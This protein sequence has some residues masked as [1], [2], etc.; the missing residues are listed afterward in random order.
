MEVGTGAR[1]AF[2]LHAPIEVPSEEFFSALRS[3][4]EDLVKLG[5][6]FGAD[7]RI[8][9]Q[10]PDDTAGASDSIDSERPI[11][12]EPIQGAVE[13]SVTDEQL[14]VLPAHAREIGDLL[15][16]IADT[17][18]SIV[19]VGPMHHIVEPKA[20]D[21]F[22]SLTFKR[23]KGTT[24][25]QLHEWWLNQHPTVVCLLMLPDMLAYDQVHVDH[26]L[27]EQTALD[28]GFTYRCYDSYDNLTFANF[29]GYV[30]S[31]SKPGFREEIWADEVGHIDHMTYVGALMNVER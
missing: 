22:L 28:A 13:F 16:D 3:R 14:L 26:G 9:T 4:R 17:E 29:D 2:M 6:S 27:G 20:G 15:S 24:L 1:M 12:R 11:A 5:R 21:L 30:R 18:R 25:Q 19:T 10:H 8:G 31:I 23:E 7:V